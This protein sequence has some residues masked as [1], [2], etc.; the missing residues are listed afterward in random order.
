MMKKKLLAI[1]Y[2]YLSFSY[3]FCFKVHF[4]GISYSQPSST[5]DFYGLKGKKNMY[6][7][8]VIVYT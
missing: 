7:S 8:T 4:S 3:F 5:P 1:S 6:M 2:F